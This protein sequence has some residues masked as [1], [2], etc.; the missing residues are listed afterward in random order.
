MISTSLSFDLQPPILILFGPPKSCLGGAISGTIRSN[1]KPML[2]CRAALIC[3]TTTRNSCCR[4]CNTTKTVVDF[5]TFQTNIGEYQVPIWFNVPGNSPSSTKCIFGSVA[6]HIQATVEF[7]NGMSVE[8]HERLKISRSEYDIHQLSFRFPP[9]L[10]PAAPSYDGVQ[11]FIP[12]VFTIGESFR[13]KFEL[14]TIGGWQ[15]DSMEIKAYQ[16]IE[17][18]GIPCQSHTKKRDHTFIQCRSNLV[19]EL[20][21]QDS[22]KISG[23]TPNQLTVGELEVPFQGGELAE[24]MVSS[25]SKGKLTIS[26]IFV[27]TIFLAEKKVGLHVEPLNKKRSGV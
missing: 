11:F 5:T 1:L 15:L 12:S 21:C 3:V 13:L 8:I 16:N 4:Q 7:N 23:R 9:P 27:I 17:S 10:S 22:W 20:I 24:T 18:I 6:Y 14:R 19:A 2:I 26:H 25:H